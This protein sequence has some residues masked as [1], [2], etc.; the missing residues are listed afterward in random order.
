MAGDG[1]REGQGDAG[2][3]L[4]HGGPRAARPGASSTE[5]PRAGGP[6]PRQPRYGSR[7]GQAEGARRAPAA[8]LW[9]AGG[10][11]GP[12][13]LCSAAAAPRGGGPRVHGGVSLR[14][15]FLGGKQRHGERRH[16]ACAGGGRR[17]SVGDLLSPD[18]PMLCSGFTMLN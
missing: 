18:K 7:R 2:A 13:R 17:G 10:S 12:S 4:R 5:V 1:Q 8:L 6:G 15:A 16:S 11:R 14:T 3:V 9:R